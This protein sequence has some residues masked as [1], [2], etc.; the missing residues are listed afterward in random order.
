MGT[1]TGSDTPSVSTLWTT[2]ASPGLSLHRRTCVSLVW[3]LERRWSQEVERTQNAWQGVRS[4]V[5]QRRRISF[6]Y[7]RITLHRGRTDTKDADAL[8]L[9]SLPSPPCLPRCLFLDLDPHFRQHRQ[10]QTHTK[11]LK[12]YSAFVCLGAFVCLYSAFVCFYSGWC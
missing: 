5:T 7:A 8:S 9:S 2:R 10:R 11:V 1:V 6:T 3:A 12:D 4:G